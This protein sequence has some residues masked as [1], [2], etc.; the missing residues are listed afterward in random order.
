MNCKEDII[1]LQRE[2]EANNVSENYMTEEQI[3]GL[4]KLYDEQIVLLEE[5]AAM[6]KDKIA[7]RKKE[8]EVK[9]KEL[10]K[11]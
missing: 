5:M 3:E 11:K 8:I 6:Y 4:H 10:N 2:F 9:M 7:K 1:K